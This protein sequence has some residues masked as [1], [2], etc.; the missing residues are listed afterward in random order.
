MNSEP[1]IS[2][3]DYALPKVKMSE[4]FTE[5]SEALYM[6]ADE[7]RN[8]EY[9][10]K[11]EVY[12]VGTIGFALMTGRPPFEE[13]TAQE[14]KNSHALKLP[15]RIST[16]KFDNT[17]PKDLEEVIEKCLEKDPRYRFETIQALLE[18]LQVFPQREQRRVNGVLAARRQK[19]ILI[20]V[21]LVVAVAGVCAL[22]FAGLGH[23]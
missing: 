19:K 20:I 13:G 2:V 7:A 14:I 12:A 3:L 6:S 1:S 8:M 15:P 9:N 4:Q 5:P 10:E 17:R 11:S 21:G 16:L 22:A 23:H 18:R